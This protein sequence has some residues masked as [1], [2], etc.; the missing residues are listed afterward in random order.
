MLILR[1]MK[2]FCFIVENGDLLTEELA[3]IFG[4]NFGDGSS[5]P[6]IHCNS[7]GVVHLPPPKGGPQGPQGPGNSQPSTPPPSGGGQGKPK[8]KRPR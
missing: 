3:S 2:D 7:N 8:K 5:G 1:T 4:G 6:V